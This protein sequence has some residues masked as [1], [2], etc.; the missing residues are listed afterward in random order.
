METIKIGFLGGCINNQKGIAPEEFYFSLFSGLLSDTPHQISAGTYYTFDNMFNKTQTFANNN[1]LD[2][3]CLWVR[4]FPLMPLHKPFV[5]YEN[6]K[7]R[8][9]WAIHPALFKRKLIWD[10]RLTKYHTQNE[11]VYKKRSR[12]EQRDFNL[13][14]GAIFGLHKWA[15]KYINQEVGAVRDFC[16]ENGIKLI[17]ISPQ[18]CPS[19]AMGD[20]VCRWISA[21][22]DKYC[23]KQEINY[24]NIIHFG[25][26]FYAKDNVHFNAA[27][28]KEL[29]GLIYIEF[30]KVVKI[31]EKEIL[32]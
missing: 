14:A 28:H 4:Q 21:S 18:Q 30:N 22:L 19:S 31:Q 23:K 3:L 29:A 6:S 2:V 24:I 32:I 13:L 8:I 17:V 16:N 7:G 15:Q 25:R 26:G 5:K 1:Q 11:Y 12:F 10:D 9:S 20:A 27:C